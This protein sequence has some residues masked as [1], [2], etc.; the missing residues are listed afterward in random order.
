LFVIGS[1]LP[2]IPTL[3]HLNLRYIGW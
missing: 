1:P 3:G 2:S